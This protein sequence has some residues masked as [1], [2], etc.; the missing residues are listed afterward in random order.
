MWNY[1][2]YGNPF[3]TTEITVIQFL[4]YLFQGGKSY[5]VL[6][7]HKAMLLQT[8]PFFVNLWC[9]DCPL[10]RR[11]MKGVYFKRR[12]KPR[13]VFTWDVS[14]VLKYLSTLFPLSILPLK[15]L[16]FKVTAL[17]AL[18]TAARAQILVS[19]DLDHMVIVQNDVIFSFP[20]VLK[21]TRKGHSYCL[22]IEHYSDES[23]C[24]MHTYLKVTRKLRH[25]RNVL[26]SCVTYNKVTTSTVARWLK[27]VLNLSGIDTDK[28]K[29]HSYRTASASA[30]FNRGCSLK[31]ILD[32]ADWSSEKNFRMFYFRYSVSREQM[33]YVNAVFKK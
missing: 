9:K 32:T 1:I 26:V 6:N 24:A 19:M 2:R 22:K 15:L 20:N 21:T 12:P 13:Y 25:T 17:I 16:T 33:S 27:L 3:Q 31:R 11:F 10:I 18:A 14:C 29:A 23:L 8:L 7:S 4:N 30:A 5:S 28:F